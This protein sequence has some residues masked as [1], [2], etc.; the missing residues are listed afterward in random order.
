MGTSS[1]TSLPLILADELDAD[2]KRVKIEQAIGD[3]RYGDRK[4]PTAR[5]R[6][7]RFFDLMRE[8]GATARLMLMRAAPQQWGVPASRM[9]IRSAHGRS[10]V[11]RPQGWL[12]GA[13]R[14]RRETAGAEER[15]V[16][17]QAARAP[18]ATSARAQVR[19]DLR[20][21]C[22]GKASYRHGRPPGRHGLRVG[23][24]SAGARRQGEVLRRQGS[25]AGAGRAARPCP[26]IPSSRRMA[27]SRWAAWP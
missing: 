8:A 23:R 27:F 18:G 16:E 10:Q 24:A 9:R 15:G 22:T 12:W 1:R 2:W 21:I 25:A 13:G 20:D 11:Q 14:C 4:I 17:V 19:Y 7:A 6:F 5:T 26:S 3:A